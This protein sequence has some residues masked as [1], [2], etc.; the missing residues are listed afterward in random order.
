[1][2][3][4]FLSLV[5]LALMGQ[6]LGQIQNYSPRQDRL[7]QHLFYLA[8]DSLRGRKAGSEDALKAANYI[9]EQYRN[10]GLKPLFEEMMVPFVPKS[11][12][13]SSIIVGDQGEMVDN[14]MGEL[15]KDKHYHNVIAVIEGSDPELKHEFI[16]LGAH[17]DHLGVRADGE[18]YNGAD[19]NASGS[20]AL[21]EIGR[22]LMQHQSELKRS[23]IIVAFDGEE[24]GLFGS[25]HFAKQLFADNDE[26]V[27]KADLLKNRKIVCMMSIDMVGWLKQG[28]TLKLEGTG[29]LDHFARL[30]KNIA[31]DV[32]IAIHCKGFENSVFT[33][34]D[35]EPFAKKGVP[36]LAITT[37]LKS[38]YHK[39]GDDP[40]L[41]DYEGLDKV[42]EYLSKL[43]LCMAKDGTV[44]SSGK[45]A[46]K[47]DD[48]AVDYRFRMALLGGFNRMDMQFKE[49]GLT[50]NS[51]VGWQAGVRARLRLKHWWLQADGVFHYPRTQMPGLN[52]ENGTV[53][54]VDFETVA[55]P[56][57]TV[58]VLLVREA[59]M[60]G[61]AINV[62]LGGYYSFPLQTMPMNNQCVIADNPWGL[63][64]SLGVRMGK[65]G[66]DFLWYYQMN[67]RFAPIQG[68]NVPSIKSTGINVNL[69][70]WL[71]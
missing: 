33:A 15:K 12:T 29:T 59:S 24:E 38:P 35:T 70:Y 23:V 46:A 32:D 41:I 42:V 28:K 21:I 39:V 17:Y 5:F 58:P 50:A 3:R 57:V 49:I 67:K 63:C 8:S 6:V 4:F 1:M 53:S 54:Y 11:S 14:L 7:K 25:Y 37:G 26:D 68:L 20:A 71:W 66:V 47:H 36:T 64:W 19:D 62:G 55:Q 27:R 9:Q 30:A 40:E 16:V 18:V 45:L 61:M 69:T 60:S 31:N 10:N 43:T 44:C 2:K 65:M 13:Y 34:T 52:M 56:S 22:E 48:A 51:K